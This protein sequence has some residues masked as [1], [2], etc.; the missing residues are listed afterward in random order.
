MNDFKANNVFTREDFRERLWMKT[1]GELVKSG[2][3]PRDA[4]IKANKLERARMMKLSVSEARNNL[5][6]DIFSM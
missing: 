1:H 3:T 5:K 2:L 6:V 4:Y